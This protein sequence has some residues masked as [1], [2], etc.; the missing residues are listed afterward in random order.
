MLVLGIYL[1]N[2]KVNYYLK[3]DEDNLHLG[4]SEKAHGTPSSTKP[5]HSNYVW[6]YKMV[7]YYRYLH[8]LY[9][10][11]LYNIKLKVI[12]NDNCGIYYYLY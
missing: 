12:F 8:I 10:S 7:C 5:S 9:V 11:E 3:F 2:K 1:F 6:L 4:A